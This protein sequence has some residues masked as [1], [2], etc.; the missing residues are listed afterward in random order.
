MSY[1][2]KSQPKNLNVYSTNATIQTV[3]TTYIDLEGSEVLYEPH[4]AAEKVIYEYTFGYQW[5]P[6]SNSIGQVIIQKTNNGN[7]V[8]LDEEY[9]KIPIGASSTSYGASTASLFYVLD[10]W[11]GKEKI[12]LIIRSY[13][14]SYE[15]KVH[16]VRT[17]GQ[18][19]QDKKVFPT[20]RIYSI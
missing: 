13:S 19:V 8:S 16:T 6:D 18:T 4:P 20:L 9:R 3:G 2:I 15:F 7:Y 17:Y 1:V 5:H 10:A 14:G 12:K 11:K